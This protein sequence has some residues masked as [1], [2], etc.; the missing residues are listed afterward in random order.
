MWV[1][2]QHGGQAQVLGG[3]VQHQGAGVGDAPVGPG[4][5]RCADGGGVLPQI[6]P[7]S[8]STPAWGQPACKAA[9]LAPSQ[10]GAAMV[11]PP[12]FWVTLDGV[13]EGRLQVL[14]LGDDHLD[15]RGLLFQGGDKSF[16]C[17]GWGPLV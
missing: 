5:G 7:T 15:R 9:R 16:G 8:N 11:A 10:P 17:H 12:C 4:E 3:G 13:S 6:L 1:S 14:D 2:E